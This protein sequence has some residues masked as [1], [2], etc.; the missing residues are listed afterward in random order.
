MSA[1]GFII[2]IIVF[3][4]SLFISINLSLIFPNTI[5]SS[6]DMIKIAILLLGGSSIFIGAI[7]K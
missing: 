4:I 2:G 6:L 7:S 1:Q 3:F 5:G